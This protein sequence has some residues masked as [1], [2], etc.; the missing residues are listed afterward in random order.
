MSRLIAEGD[1]CAP[2]AAGDLVEGP[3]ETAGDPYS[4]DLIAYN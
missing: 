3:Q 4:I 1:L 2:V